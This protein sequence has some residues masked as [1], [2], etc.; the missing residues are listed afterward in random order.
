MNRHMYLQSA[1]TLGINDNFNDMAFP[2]MSGVDYES[3]NYDQSLYQ[4]NN[5]GFGVPVNELNSFSA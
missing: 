5:S 3:M 1:G 4:V 2:G